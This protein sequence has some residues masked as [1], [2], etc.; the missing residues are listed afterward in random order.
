MRAVFPEPTGLACVSPRGRHVVCS[1]W[2]LYGASEGKN[3]P[4]NAYGESSFAPV[5]SFNYGHL[6]SEI[7]S[8]A[9]ENLVGVAMFGGREAIMGMARHAIVCMSMR[10]I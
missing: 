3:L 6:P 8:R 2:N 5:P 10:H 7:A 4:A 9:V 1:T